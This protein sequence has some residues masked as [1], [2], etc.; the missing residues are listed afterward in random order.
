MND[1]SNAAATN[2]PAAP[3]RVF[4]LDGSALAYRAHFAF[5]RTP[6]SNAS[7]LNTGA[8]FGY[9]KTLLR[10]LEGE[11][12]DYIAVV[13]DTKE[14]TFRHALY[15]DY[16]ATRQKMPEEMVE[17]LP[18]MKRV[19][20]A[21]GVPLIEKPGFEADDVIGT[22]AV[23]AAK[24]GADVLVVTGDKDFMQ[25]VSPRIRLYNIMKPDS[26]VLIV[27]EAEVEKKFGVPPERVID[28]L[29]LM[30][31]SSDN[32]PGVPGV[33]EKTAAEL[34]R[35][36]GSFD[37]VLDRAAEIKKPK[38]RASLLEN[39]PIAELSRRLVTISV[40]VPGCGAWDSLLRS[41]VDYPRVVE[42]YRELGFTSLLQSVPKPK[43]AP[44]AADYRI[45]GSID[46]LRRL[47]EELAALPIFAVDTETTSLVRRQ[48][49][50][51]GISLTSTSGSG[52][53]VP[54]KV[55]G[56]LAQIG[57]P[58][59]FEAD[60]VW[61][62]LKPILEN[63]AV[64]K[65]G[66]NIKYDMGVFGNHGV[67]L[68]GA[69]FDTMIASYLLDSGG[70]EHDLDS[71]A[72]KHFKY[73]KI[74]TTE[75][76]GTGKNQITMDR[77][78]VEKVAEYACEDV[79][80]T[81]RLHELFAAKLAER[82][83]QR[84][85]DEIEMPL[86]EVLL[87]MERSGIKVDGKILA[88]LDRELS[89]EI[90][91]L[92]KEIHALAG[93]P[94]NVASPKQL[95]TLIFDK[96][97]LHKLAGIKPQKTKTGWST[98]QETLEAMG[99]LPL[100]KLI[101]EH[102]SLTKLLGT[103]VTTLPN[104]IDPD[105]RKI[106]TSFNQTI[107]ATGRLSSSDPNLQNIPIRSKTGKRIRE[108]FIASSPAHRLLSADY[109]QIELRIMA[110]A[111][112]DPVMIESFL[113]GVDIHRE[114]AARIFQK[115]LAEIDAAMRS[116]AKTINFGILY[117]MGKMRLARET[118]M[119][120]DEAQAFI[121]RYFANFPAVK[122]YIEKMKEEARKTGSVTTLLGRQRAIPDIDSKNGA[123]RSAAENMAVN[124]PIQ[125][126]AA[127]LIKIAM[128][129]ID[130]WILRENLSGRMV[131]QVHDELLF[132]V[133]LGEVETFKNEVPRLMTSVKA[134]RVP[135]VVD[136]GVGNNWAEAH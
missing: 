86:V 18:Y 108:A 79:D 117:G 84:L 43:S 127:D 82:G 77:V 4:L 11:K 22:L 39:R 33:G 9:V 85:F 109:S 129:A 6:L 15:G 8:I 61:P 110:H 51:V 66:Q 34:I 21:L 12:P 72:L 128:I 20:T 48:A 102:R 97:E 81:W 37:A 36:Y 115:P 14:P 121:D 71:L 87:R 126:T 19:T 24:D 62:I 26:D 27:D 73:T 120:Q 3:K 78:P 119:T 114:T 32:V 5:A 2:P 16:K 54:L 96:L 1:R 107:A 67:E 40:D 70:R 35:E 91:R 76:I 17:Q 65:V 100:P 99:D 124:T 30:G 89:G 63:P 56:S 45:V 136:M 113:R 133:P 58:R 46:E 131:L 132:D 60:D 101:L 106:H 10:V 50:I 105:T 123:L 68:R 7:G 41:E 116:H 112:D 83:L 49:R 69:A 88:E 57:D 28:V 90:A 64:K 95:A 53:Y 93:E 38:L 98:N 55:S 135:L 29:A 13:F 103:Y 130:A 44:L 104:L 118:G 74:K 80:F 31:D 47:G 125:G 111:A 25:I 94:V 75:L 92:E 59:V 52:R 134:L 23:E 42:L 122:G